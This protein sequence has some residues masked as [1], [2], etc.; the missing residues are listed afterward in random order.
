M[1]FVY[2][3]NYIIKLYLILCSI[4][5]KE[6]F[7]LPKYKNKNTINFIHSKYFTETI[8]ESRE[9][10]FEYFNS[11]QKD[12]NEDKKNIFNYIKKYYDLNFTTFY[13]FTKSILFNNFSIN[14]KNLISDNVL[15]NIYFKKKKF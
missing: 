1:M 2:S 12:F 6:I 5:G 3:Y 7:Y 9:R 11:F 15:K 14:K 8:K 13:V 4:I 10:V